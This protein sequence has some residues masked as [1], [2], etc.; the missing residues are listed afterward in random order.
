MGAQKNVPK[1]K[2]KSKELTYVCDLKR[3]CIKVLKDVAL[4]V[5]DV[6]SI[7]IIHIETTLTK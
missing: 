1:K 6:D 2:V 7:Q 5:V 4:N 3:N